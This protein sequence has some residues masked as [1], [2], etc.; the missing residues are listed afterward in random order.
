MPS[1][2]AFFFRG[3]LDKA[4]PMEIG[5]S[6]ELISEVTFSLIVTPNRDTI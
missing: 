1:G 2:M 4:H 3:T 5:V 6:L